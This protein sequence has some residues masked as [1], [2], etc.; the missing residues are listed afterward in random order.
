[1][2]VTCGINYGFDPRQLDSGPEL[3]P[4]YYGLS[5]VTVM[6]AEPAVV[7]VDVGACL[8]LKAGKLLKR[9]GIDVR[10]HP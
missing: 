9:S 8:H 3:R 1:L 6:T 5:I 10:N 7:F 2:P 4:Y